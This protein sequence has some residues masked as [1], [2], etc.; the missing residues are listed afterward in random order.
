MIV[1]VAYIT[2]YTKKIGCVVYNTQT[3]K[4]EDCQDIT[5]AKDRDLPVQDYMTCLTVIIQ[6]L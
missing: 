4:F 3:N 6:L 5:I 2:Q 1:P